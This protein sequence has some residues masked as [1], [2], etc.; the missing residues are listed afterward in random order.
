MSALTEKAAASLAVN[1]ADGKDAL[2]AVMRNI[3]AADD[4]S[5]LYALLAYAPQGAVERPS[6][7]RS[8]SS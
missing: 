7:K 6:L 5:G 3:F 2:I 1:C 8:S 4:L